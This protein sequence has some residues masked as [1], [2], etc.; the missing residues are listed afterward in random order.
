MLPRRAAD[1]SGRGGAVS[2]T[3][4]RSCHRLGDYRMRGESQVIVGGKVDQ[5]LASNGN[6]RA[7]SSFDN[8]QVA[9]KAF[10]PEFRKLFSQIGFKG[11]HG[12]FK[13]DGARSYLITIL[14]D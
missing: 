4:G 3:L 11:I 12:L 10:C 8:I 1:Q 2:P 13:R 7:S 9:A 14:W 5:F 6:T